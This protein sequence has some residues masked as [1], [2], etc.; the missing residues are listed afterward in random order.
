[1][2]IT[3]IPIGEAV[4]LP[5][6]HDLTL[7][8]TESRYKGARFRRGQI[9]TEEDLPL[10]RKM[11]RINLS[12]MDMEDDE[13]HEDEAALALA[14]SLCGEGLEITGPQ[15][16]RCRLLA[17]YA[18]IV[19]FSSK[20]VSK[21]NQE[22]NW[23]LA[24]CPINSIVHPGK[25]VVS[26]RILPLVI[27][28]PFLDQAIM[29]AEP[30]TV[31]PFL[32]QRVG[33]VTTGSEIKSGL[34]KDIFEERLINKLREL[35]GSYQGQIICGDGTEEIQGAIRCML[36]TGV[37][38]VICT[39]GMSVDADDRTPHAIR[40]SSDE[41]I[42]RGVPSQPGANLMLAKKGDNWIIGAPAC[43]VH[44]ERTTL[45]R[46]LIALFAGLGKELNVP[47]WGLGGLCTHC[48][49]CIFPD[50]DF[51]RLPDKDF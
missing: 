35:G 41:V 31:L 1:M 13:I 34:V 40:S 28:Q 9:I 33:L 45:D 20:S 19:R 14:K 44:D 7:I 38:I 36:E 32:H 4:G 5:L 48:R 43:V 10:L 30:V 18:G 46:L 37:D 47:S 51:A 15:E 3:T 39:G 49:F 50:C 6:A 24:T 22:R 16:G 29:D 26:L 25:P 42:F 8:D 17:K 11:G 12:I 21:I 27:R 2:K 23:S